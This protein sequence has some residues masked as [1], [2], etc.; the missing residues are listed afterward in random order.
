MV[1]VMTSY[2]GIKWD[3]LSFT[4]TL[5]LYPVIDT[6]LEIAPSQMRDELR[7]GLQEALV[8]A[9]KH[10]NS[11]DP[12][13]HISVQYAKVHDTYWWIITDQGSGFEFP[14]GCR[15]CSDGTDSENTDDCGRGL[16]ILHQIFD[17][18]HWSSKGNE[19]H[20]CKRF[21]RWPSW[22]TWWQGKWAAKDTLAIG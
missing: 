5:Y 10:G 19:V 18:V 13:K 16:F 12:S 3:K 1:S 20:L 8:N 14:H 21:R 7:L 11:L 2:A 4:S 9:A 15:I 17:Q 6:L 22:L